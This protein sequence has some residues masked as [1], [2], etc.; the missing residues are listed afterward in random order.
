MVC[1]VNTGAIDQGLCLA[2]LFGKLSRILDMPKNKNKILN[3]PRQDINEFCVT[4]YITSV[5][6]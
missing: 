2:S 4:I 1:C 3:V 6:L 5:S